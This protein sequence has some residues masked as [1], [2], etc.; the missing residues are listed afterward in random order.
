MLRANLILFNEILPKNTEKNWGKWNDIIS[1]LKKIV[2]ACEANVHNYGNTE[3]IHLF[4][5]TP[6]TYQ[7]HNEHLTVKF[8]F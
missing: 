6:I 5:D 4:P 7:K 3:L 1:I 8:L 2:K